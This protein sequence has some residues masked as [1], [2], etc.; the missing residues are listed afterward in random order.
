MYR[1]AKLNKSLGPETA[2]SRSV[3]GRQTLRERGGARVDGSPLGFLKPY[4]RALKARTHFTEWQNEEDT[5]RETDCMPFM[6]CMVQDRSDC[7][8]ATYMRP[9]HLWNTG[10]GM[11]IWENWMRKN[12]ENVAEEVYFRGRKARCGTS[13]LSSPEGKTSRLWGGNRKGR[14][15]TRDM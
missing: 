15:R 2:V 8:K 3:C 6:T 10:H 12:W 5:F 9:V 14:P 13:G 7:C 4:E 1:S 11:G